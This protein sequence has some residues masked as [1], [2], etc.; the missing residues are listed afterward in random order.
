MHD[1]VSITVKGSFLFLI[2]VFLWYYLD[3]KLG[4]LEQYD[5]EMSLFKI[6]F[7]FVKNVLKKRKLNVRRQTKVDEK[8]RKKENVLKWILQL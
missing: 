4:L 6:I 5:R 8:V 7:K 2:T 1:N 3:T